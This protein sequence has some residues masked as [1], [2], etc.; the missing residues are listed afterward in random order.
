[1]EPLRGEAYQEVI[2]STKSPFQ[3]QLTLEKKV[4]VKQGHPTHLPLLY[5]ANSFLLLHHVGDTTKKTL[6]R[7]QTGVVTQSWTSR[8]QNY[9]VNKLLFFTKYPALSTF[10]I[11]TQGGLRHTLFRAMTQGNVWTL[12]KFPVTTR[13]LEPGA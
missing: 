1:V 12:Y 7:G 2:W 9:D 6:P 11:S 4:V 5:M 8:L 10:V 3:E 13:H